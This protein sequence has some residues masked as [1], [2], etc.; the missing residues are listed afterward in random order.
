MLCF[1]V[2][3]PLFPCLKYVIGSSASSTSDQLLRASFHK[4]GTQLL[5]GKHFFNY[6]PCH[7]E[8]DC[9]SFFYGVSFQTFASLKLK[10]E[11]CWF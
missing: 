5:E 11:A 3:N 7:L 9:L 8:E 1:D 10:R 6:I 4:I 2:E